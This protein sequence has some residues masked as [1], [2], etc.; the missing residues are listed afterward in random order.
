MALMLFP[1]LKFS[2]TAWCYCQLLE[3]KKYIIEMPSSSVMRCA[4]TFVITGRLDEKL[5]LGVFQTH[6]GATLWCV[7]PPFWRRK[8]GEKDPIL[9]NF[10]FN[11]TA[12]G[13]CCIE[14]KRALSKKSPLRMSLVSH[15]L[16]YIMF[17]YPS[18]VSPSSNTSTVLFNE[19][20]EGRKC[21]SVFE[22]VQ[23]AAHN[24]AVQNVQN[25]AANPSICIVVLSMGK[26][27]L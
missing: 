16:V 23:S 8:S 5:E 20:W 3:I 26:T 11:G 19:G 7:H 24:L 6:T 4:W 10:V 12:I 9:L 14:S 13:I 1:L 18:H 17:L 21:A 22:G 2:G 15:I 25:C 27:W